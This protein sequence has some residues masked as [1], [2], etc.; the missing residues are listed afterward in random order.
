MRQQAC[1]PDFRNL[2]FVLRAVVMA[3]GLRLL[4][5]L[6]RA[7]DWHQLPDV[8]AS[9]GVFFESTLL[10]TLAALA[11]GSPYFKTLSYWMGCAAVAVLACTCALFW[12]FWVADWLGAAV[13]VDGVLRALVFT[14]LITAALL[15]YFNWRHHRHSPAW[16]ESRLMALQ[17]RIRP[18][19]LFNSLNSVLALIRSEPRKAEAMLEDLAE[20]FRALLAE[21]R[22]L[23]PLSDEL[24]L[25]RSYIAIEAI[26]LGDR[27]RV[28]WVCDP[29]VDATL[30]PPLLLQ[31]LLENAVRYGVEPLEGGADV[32][33]VVAREG[34]YL[35]LTVRNP[36]PAGDAAVVAAED[37][38]RPDGGHDRR[39]AGSR[40]GNRMALANIKERLLLH[41]DAEAELR[42]AMEGG[43]H[44]TRVR[45][46][47]SGKL[48]T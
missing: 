34:N 37:E 1:L 8:F 18:H 9:Q 35:V 41:F 28:H 33:V 46:P 14:S 10:T 19:F 12:H 27:L 25:A 40:D 16:A 38:A 32:N 5:T 30:V 7:D 3:E 42:T 13:S 22:T 48:K 43:E 47:L 29:A 2:G 15:F 36:L 24:A 11:I 44:I 23:V 31:P 45:L 20:L 39:R 26:R 17:S 6:I 4:A 21:P